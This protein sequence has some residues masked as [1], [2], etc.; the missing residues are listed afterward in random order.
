MSNKPNLTRFPNIPNIGIQSYERYLPNAFD[1]SLS[2]LQKINKV[3][4]QLNMIGEISNRLVEQWNE[5]MEW[6]VGN[7]L[8]DIVS[9]EFDKRIQ[10]GTFDELIYR[11]VG[12]L[13]ELETENKTDLVKAINEIFNISTQN[14]Q[15]IGNMEELTTDD[16]STL[17]NAINEIETQTNI[18]NQTVISLGEST[19]YGVISGFKVHQQNVLAM[20]VEIGNSTTPNIV[21]LPNGERYELDS[22]ALS[23]KPSETLPRMDSVF[24]NENGVISYTSGQPSTNPVPPVLTDNSVLLAHITVA[25]GDTTV[26]DVDIIDKRPLKSLKDLK[27]FEKDNFVEAINELFDKIVQ[28]ANDYATKAEIGTLADLET[29][30]KTTIVNAINEVIANTYTQLNE[31]QEQV[32]SEI[33]TLET[34]ET[35]AKDNLVN[36]INEVIANTYEQLNDLQTKVDSEIGDLILLET[37]VKD[38][39]VN[40]INNVLTM[41][42]SQLEDLEIGVSGELGNL[43]ELNTVAKNNIVSAINEIIETTNNQ[44]NDLELSINQTIGDLTLLQTTDKNNV[45]NAVNELVDKTNTTNEKV[46]QLKNQTYNVKDYGIIADGEITQ[47]EANINTPLFKALIETVYNNGGGTIVVDG[48]IPLNKLNLTIGTNSYTDKNHIIIE[49]SNKGELV[50]F[51]PTANSWIVYGDDT[52]H[53]QARIIWKDIIFNANNKN[54]TVIQGE[55]IPNDFTKN[56]ITEMYNCKILKFKGTGINFGAMTDCEFVN[57]LLEGEDAEKGVVTSRENNQLHN[58]KIRYCT[59][60]VYVRN[61]IESAIKMIGGSIMVCKNMVTFE[62]GGYIYSNSYFLGT[63]MA[64]PREGDNVIH[65]VNPVNFNMSQLTFSSVLF[66][67][68]NP[69]KNYLIDLENFGGNITFDNCCVWG[70]A[71]H[72]NVRVGQYNTIVVSNN[73]GLTFEGR[74]DLINAKEKEQVILTYTL[75]ANNVSQLS[76]ETFI[77]PKKMKVLSISGMTSDLADGNVNIGLVRNGNYLSGA[78]VNNVQNGVTDELIKYENIV[79][80]QNDKLKV[81]F[82]PTTSTTD[83]D[84]YLTLLCLTL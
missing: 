36:A 57:I 19:G 71:T 77:I 60:G 37:D 84:I 30:E 10:D 53:C 58:V 73:Y 35:V 76:R 13:T 46:Q 64:E 24:V 54:I 14:N 47:E 45:V 27:T 18:N 56:I 61:F 25:V 50:C 79:L 15:N 5:L 51:E 26:N 33:G 66:N 29:N 44:L 32:N 22:L 80:E 68:Q 31:L 8:T 21:H 7:G 67:S 48:I 20:A 16:K 34:L 40:A 23:V 49:A 39:L 1:E 83:F 70:Y 42:T 81:H 17:V 9:A 69:S 72:K 78:S 3:I 82:Y 65:V 41:V 28:V 12:N 74:I 52:K 55:P 38:T 75:K 4:Q 63:Y 6:I 11:I 59:H 43:S 62:G 2:I